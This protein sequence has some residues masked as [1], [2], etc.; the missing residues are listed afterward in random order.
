MARCK[1]AGEFGVATATAFPCVGSVLPF[2]LEGVGAIATQAWVN[3]NYGYQGLELMRTGL[4]VKSAIETLPAE[5]DGRA[6][7]LVASPRTRLF[8]NIW[9]DSHQNPA[10]E[11]RRIFKECIKLEGDGGVTSV[12]WMSVAESVACKGD[13]SRKN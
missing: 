10:K 13:W 8:H 11:L 6:E 12:L 5:D 9:V 7:L 3:V 1:K 2:A 4:S